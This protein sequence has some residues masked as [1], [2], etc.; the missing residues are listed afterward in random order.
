MTVAEAAEVHEAEL[1]AQE[2]M[3]A[4]P[5]DPAPLMQL[6]VL[7]LHHRLY[8]DSA[9]A[10]ERLQL[11]LPDNPELLRLQAHAWAALSLRDR[12]RDAEQRAAALETTR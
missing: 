6:M 1:R 5:N 11:I 7:Y 2:L 9:A 12:A 4:D 3:K 10:G 8:A